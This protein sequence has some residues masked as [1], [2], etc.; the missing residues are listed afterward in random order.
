MFIKTHPKSHHLWVD[1]TLSKDVDAQ[2]S[3]TVYDI[4]HLDKEPKVLK[5]TDKA[6]LSIW[7]II[8]GR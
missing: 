3:V 8:K 6:G 2:R 4:R 1:H 5:L 7:N